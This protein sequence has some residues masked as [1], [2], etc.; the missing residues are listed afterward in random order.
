MNIQ[1]EVFFHIC[2][3][4]EDSKRLL[5]LA[6][7]PRDLTV[8]KS[9]KWSGDQLNFFNEFWN[10]YSYTIDSE[11]QESVDIIQ[12]ARD[13]LC[14]ETSVFYEKHSKKILQ[15]LNNQAMFIRETIFEEIRQTEFSELPS[16]KSCLWVSDPEALPFWWDSFRG[17]R[18]ILKLKLSGIYILEKIVF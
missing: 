8:G 12:A 16:R 5:K 11:S 1:D 18:T 9:L 4:I 2:H 10:H 3:S 15:V 17:E 7:N 13:S 6:K 14:E